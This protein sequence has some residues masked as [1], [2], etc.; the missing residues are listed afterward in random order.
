LEKPRLEVPGIGNMTK[1]KKIFL[2]IAAIF[3]ILAG[4]FYVFRFQIGCL[5][6][7][8]K[9][10]W[11]APLIKAIPQSMKIESGSAPVSTITAFDYSFSVPWPDCLPI[12]SGTSLVAWA[13]SETNVTVACFSP[14]EGLYSAILSN[15]STENDG[16]S[17][18]MRE[19]FGLE[20]VVNTNFHLCAQALEVTPGDISLFDSNRELSGKWILLC[21]KA[22]IVPLNT[23]EVYSFEYNGIKGFQFGNPSVG[24]RIHLLL[25]DQMDREVQLAV[26][27]RTNS[28]ISITQAD[29]NTIIT[30][31]SINP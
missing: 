18:V 16:R 14:S 23:S 28:S 6:Y 29:I 3:L 26:G 10:G 4:S 17:Q 22:V 27:R 15:V 21:M 7:A 20:G 8:Q 5:L 30:T 13:C 24:K 11:E 1:K 2:G 25:F 12:Y 31:F 9:A 19:W